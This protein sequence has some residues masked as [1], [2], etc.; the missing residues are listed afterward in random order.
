VQQQVHG[1]DAQ[2]SGTVSALLGLANPFGLLH[3]LGNVAEWTLDPYV[4]DHAGL[5]RPGTGEHVSDPEAGA[6]LLRVA[7]GGSFLSTP[8]LLRSSARDE[9]PLG[10]RSLSVGMRPL[11]PID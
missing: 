6:A 10:T 8:A 1:A 3:V 5:L 11:R 4:P 2:P 9:L 7:R